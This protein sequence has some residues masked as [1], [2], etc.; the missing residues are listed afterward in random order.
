MNHISLIKRQAEMLC[1]VIHCAGCISANTRPHQLYWGWPGDEDCYLKH[2]MQPTS[3]PIHTTGTTGRSFS[4]SVALCRCASKTI[5]IIQ[6][7]II[8]TCCQGHA[9]MCIRIHAKAVEVPEVLTVITWTS[10]GFKPNMCVQTLPCVHT[11]WYMH[12]VCRKVQV[13]WEEKE[14]NTKKFS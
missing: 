7:I 2:R 11:Y 9:H 12:V 10:C 1:N 8:I 6:A 13:R 5:A 3:C 14:I 4:N